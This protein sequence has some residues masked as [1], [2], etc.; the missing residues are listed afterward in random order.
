MDDFTF[1][2]GWWRITFRQA[3][4]PCRH[5]HFRKEASRQ[6]AV[7][8]GLRNSLQTCQP[9]WS[10][11]FNRLSKPRTL[12]AYAKSERRFADCYVQPTHLIYTTLNDL[13]LQTL[14]RRPNYFLLN[15][16]EDDGGQRL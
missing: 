11:L 4:V 7:A 2:F 13:F 3:A 16:A 1:V 5:L 10:E 15:D 9:Q 6:N 14:P 12:I 8:V